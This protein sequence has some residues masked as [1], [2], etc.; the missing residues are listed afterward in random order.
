MCLASHSQQVAEQQLIPISLA[1]GFIVIISTLNCLLA[2]L[3][4]LFTVSLLLASFLPFA[5]KCI[6]N[7]LSVQ[8]D[9]EP[10]IS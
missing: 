8:L 1:P 5:C 2:K 10:R 4:L 9:G 3:V 7:T 6:R